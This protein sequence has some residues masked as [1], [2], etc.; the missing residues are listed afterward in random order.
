MESPVVWDSSEVIYRCPTGKDTGFS[1]QDSAVTLSPPLWARLLQAGWRGL[2][3][4]INWSGGPP[5]S[6]CGSTV[7]RSL[8]N[9]NTL[10]ALWI[11][12]P[13]PNKYKTKSL[14]F[15]KDQGT[16]SKNNCRKFRPRGHGRNPRPCWGRNRTIIH[17]L[18][19]SIR[20]QGFPAL[21]LNSQRDCQCRAGQHSRG[22]FGR[23]KPPGPEQPTQSRWGGENTK[24]SGATSGLSERL[25]GQRAGCL[26]SL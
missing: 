8:R 15:P 3:A 5:P 12:P 9:G 4:N 21:P 24:L 22:L 10:T 17:K 18:P 26:C 23:H 11:T 19:G 20:S 1:G 14:Q 16:T 7:S 6:T 25:P 13:A 2:A